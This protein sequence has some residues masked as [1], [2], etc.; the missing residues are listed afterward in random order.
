MVQII[1]IP[2]LH[3]FYGPDHK[4]TSVQSI[5]D[6]ILDVKTWMTPTDDKTESLLLAPNRTLQNP[7]PTSIHVRHGDILTSLQAKY[8]GV[9]LSISLSMEKHV[10]NICCSACSEIRSQ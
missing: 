3:D 8:M 10:A 4:D 1:K 9:T 2:Q 6:C 5:W 7:H